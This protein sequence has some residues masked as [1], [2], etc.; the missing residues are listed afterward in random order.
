ML[1]HLFHYKLIV[2]TFQYE[3][4]Q[5]LYIH[6]KKSEFALFNTLLNYFF[7]MIFNPVY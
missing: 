2:I 6:Q 1:Y 3:D 5:N 4:T 7:E